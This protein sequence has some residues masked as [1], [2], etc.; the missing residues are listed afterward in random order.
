MDEVGC[1]HLVGVRDGCGIVVARDHDDRHI[2]TRAHGAQCCAY[3]EA[4]A[5]R[6]FDV[7]QD[8]VRPF[9]LE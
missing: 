3:V 4:V 5:A 7:E 2:D 9:L 6:Q 1:S 8:E